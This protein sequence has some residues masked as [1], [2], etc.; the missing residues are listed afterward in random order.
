M[1]TVSCV[2]SLAAAGSL[3]AECRGVYFTEKAY[4]KVGGFVGH[5]VFQVLRQARVLVD[6][7]DLDERRVRPASGVYAAEAR[8]PP[9]RQRIGN[10]WC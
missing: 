7:A 5:E 10:P 4:P 9:E 1:P 8:V 2:A 6:V 3:Q